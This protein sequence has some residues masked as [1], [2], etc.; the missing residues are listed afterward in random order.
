MNNVE[1]LTKLGI[2]S[3]VQQRVGDFYD[4]EATPEQIEGVNEIINRMSPLDLVKAWAGWEL[5]DESWATIIIRYYEKLQSIQPK[6]EQPLYRLDFDWTANLV[7]VKKMVLDPPDERSVAGYISYP[8]V[9]T[10]SFTCTDNVTSVGYVDG[11]NKFGEQIMD[12]LKTFK[13]MKQN[14]LWVNGQN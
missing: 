7:A 4:Y 13:S 2:L 9:A 10:Y 5:G 14:Y 12:A 11:E 1:Q 3:D 6:V 8:I